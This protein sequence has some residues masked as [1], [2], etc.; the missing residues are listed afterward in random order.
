VTGKPQPGDYG[1]TPLNDADGPLI[2]LGQ[3][4]NGNGFRNY[5]HAFVWTGPDTI[6]EAEP[7]GAVEVPFHYD[8]GSCVISATPLTGTQR[9]AIVAA[10]R[11]YIGTPYSFADYAALAAHRLHIPAPGLRDYV[12]DTG[13]MICSQLTDRAF[14]DAGVHL[15]SGIWQGYVTPAMLAGLALAGGQT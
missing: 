8:L 3:F 13:H 11:S 5:E 2:R 6:V 1:C 4:L 9:T 10:A 12:A 7:G 14:C 15:F